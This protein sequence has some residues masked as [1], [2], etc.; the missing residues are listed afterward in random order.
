MKNSYIIACLIVFLSSKTIADSPPLAKGFDIKCDV[1]AMQDIAKA[2]HFEPLQNKAKQFALRTCE[3]MLANPTG[4]IND[5][6]VLLNGADNVGEPAGTKISFKTS[7]YKSWMGSFDSNLFGGMHELALDF[8]VYQPS[9]VTLVDDFKTLETRTSDECAYGNVPECKLTLDYR[10]S[11]AE[12]TYLFFEKNSLNRRREEAC[13]SM[14]FSNC[15][16]ALNDLKLAIEPYSYFIKEGHTSNVVKTLN[17][18][19]R[20]WD[21]FSEI[22]RHQTFL[23]KWLTTEIYHD[24]F[25][26]SDW[27][28]PPKYQYFLLHPSLVLDHFSSAEDGSKSEVGLAIEWI[29]INKWNGK[30]PIGVSLA[31]VY[32][33]RSTGEKTGHGLMFHIN[34]RYSIGFAKRGDGDNSVYINLNFLNWGNKQQDKYRTYKDRMGNF[35]A[36]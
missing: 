36:K 13:V 17:Q 11:T 5:V 33:D 19:N 10:S 3:N 31:S 26:G 24:K 9:G 32:A 23:D 21:K 7:L 25:S 1:T 8:V 34:N 30:I 12:L 14:G 2:K 4:V 18:L 20:E 6:N 15:V 16:D 22:S 29:G 28:T 35:R 27:A